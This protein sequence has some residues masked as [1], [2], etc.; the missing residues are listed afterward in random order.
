M[1]KLLHEIRGFAEI[2]N[3]RPKPRSPEMLLT[4]MR[5]TV[6]QAVLPRR[7]LNITTDKGGRADMPDPVRINHLTQDTTPAAT[8]PAR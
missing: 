1:L 2:T 4:Q 6:I 7:K 3:R 8:P 5:P